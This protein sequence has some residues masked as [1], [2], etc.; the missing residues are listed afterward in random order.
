MY[1]CE[2]CANNHVFLL[3]SLGCILQ[4]VSGQAVGTLFDL[5]ESRYMQERME[6][7]RQNQGKQRLAD[8]NSVL[9]RAALQ[10]VFVCRTAVL[11]PQYCLR[12]FAD[13]DSI[14]SVAASQN[15][16]WKATVLM[17]KYCLKCFV[18]NSPAEG[19]SAIDAL[20]YK[21]CNVCPLV[22]SGMLCRDQ[23]P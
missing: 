11:A 22:L 10:V 20:S 9:H 6:V 19:M 4:L 5:E 23:F 17:P 13:N 12:C 21:G 16:V 2:Y 18:P 15:V 1:T 3:L 14:L 8:D 7:E